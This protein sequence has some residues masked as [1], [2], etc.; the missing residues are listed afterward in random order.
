MI[1]PGWDATRTLAR[2]SFIPWSGSVFSLSRCLDCRDIDALGLT[3]ETLLDDLAYDAG[4]ALGLA[5][6]RRGAEGIL[7]LSATR[8]GDNLIL[9]PDN[10]QPTS[11]I[12]STADVLSLEHFVIP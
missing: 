5:A 11:R 12:E 3:L 2:M 9:F 4:H 7:V 8:A 10:L 6:V 1:P